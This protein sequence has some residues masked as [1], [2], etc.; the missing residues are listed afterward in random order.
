MTLDAGGAP[1]KAIDAAAI[2]LKDA[3]GPLHSR[4]ITE[5][6][7]ER[8]LWTTEGRTPWDTVR[9]QLAEDISVAG[10]ASHFVRAGPGVFALSAS[11]A[12][13]GLSVTDTAESEQENDRRRLGEDAESLSFT[14]AAERVLKRSADQQPLHYIEITKSSLECGLIRTEGRTPAA[15][16]SSGF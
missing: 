14:D 2:G 3:N 15:T 5:R 11:A 13:D 8:K 6:M 4:E 7:L 1:W 12:A 16:M 9:A 10:S